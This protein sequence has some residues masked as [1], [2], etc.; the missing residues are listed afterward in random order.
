MKRNSRHSLIRRVQT[1]L[2][3]GAPFGLDALARLGVSPQLAAQY[4]KGGWLVRLAH[5][6]YAFPSD[7]LEVQATVRFLQTRV[8]GLHVAGKSALALQGV[9]HNLGTRE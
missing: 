5:G 6:V 3:R 7:E 9:R 1:E 4:A 8:P 2:P